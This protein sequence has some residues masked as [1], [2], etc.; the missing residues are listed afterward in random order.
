MNKFASKENWQKYFKWLR[1]MKIV[2]MIVVLHG[3][4]LYQFATVNQGVIENGRL[5]LKNWD[6]N[7]GKALKLDGMWRFYP[8]AFIASTTATDDMEATDIYVPGRWNEQL[9]SDLGYGSYQLQIQLNRNDTK[10]YAIYLP[11]IQSASR[12]YVNGE[13]AG[14]SGTPA[15]VKHDYEPYNIPY[16]VEAKGDENGVIDI[17]VEAANYVIEGQS[18]I[19]QA[20]QFGEKAVIVKRNEWSIIIQRLVYVVLLFHV[21]YT[22][23]L[24]IMGI[25]DK[26]LL[27]LSVLLFFILLII[28]GNGSKLIFEWAPLTYIQDYRIKGVLLSIGGFVLLRCCIDKDST[29]ILIYA[30][31]ILSV[32]AILLASYA[33]TLSDVIPL[34]GLLLFPIHTVTTIIVAV[35]GIILTRTIHR[36]TYMIYMFTAF[37]CIAGWEY[38]QVLLGISTIFYPFD[39]VVIIFC[40]SALVF[41]SY[42]STVE[43]NKQ[44][45]AKLQRED[46]LKDQF[47]ANTSHELRNPLH[48]MLNLTQ[49]VLDKEKIAL[50]QRSVQNLELVLSIGRRMNILL[51]DLLDISTLKEQ[52]I[53]LVKRNVNVHQLVEKTIDSL[54]YLLDRNRISVVNEVS[55]QLQPV[56]ADENRLMQI[57]FN[58]LHNAIKFTNQGGITIKA[59]PVNGMLQISVTDT[60]QGIA[61]ELLEHIFDSYQQISPQGEV[62][63][64]GFGL[65]LS[66]TKQLVELHGS[67]LKVRSIEGKGSTFYFSLP[68]AH[69]E[70]QSEAEN[71]SHSIANDNNR[72]FASTTDDIDREALADDN[73]SIGQLASIGASKEQEPQRIKILAVDDD[74]VNL[75]VLC[76][77]L[78]SDNELD[79]YCATSAME[80][81]EMLADQQWDIIISDVMM[82]GMSGHA[83]TSII[84]E[85]YGLNELPILLLT[86]RGDVLDVEAG[87]LAG[88]NDYVAK[89]I[90]AIELYAR[91][92]T[93]VRLKRSHQEALSL[94][95]AWLQAQ[96]KPHFIVNTLNSIVALSE[97]DQNQMIELVHQFSQYLRSSHSI[98]HTHELIGLEQELQLVE[99]FLS[100]NQHRFNKLNIEWNVEEG[101]DLSELMLP[102][103]VLQSLIENAVVHGALSRV[104]NSNVTIGIQRKDR[105]VQITIRDNGVGMSKEI[106]E[107]AL[108]GKLGSGIGLYN[109]NL[110]LKQ[111]Y[112]EGLTIHSQLGQGTEVSFKIP[113]IKVVE[114]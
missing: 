48:G 72:L 65:G 102:P 19:G 1:V 58:L 90:N 108:R 29:R 18:G 14:S 78:N 39:L 87:L 2:I 11:S 30:S 45:T 63:N 21:I 64:T 77:I 5:D 12:V 38:L 20:P 74:P 26:R 109:T 57:L 105:Y 44:L 80:A 56:L 41:K 71:K 67:Q 68:F 35:I 36:G 96:I 95:A 8:N 70:Q 81:L 7:S 55:P 3:V 15:A 97:I 112:R 84:R 76:N 88:A 91:V 46:K 85:T 66:I 113:I 89:P 33:L 101:N 86:A 93:L 17:I 51:G 83:L 28:A 53:Q 92:R 43:Q 47:L 60:G 22:L 42:L 6:S 25:R 49:A 99:A 103:L 37:F 34:I 59:E 10:T 69:G 23:Q 110:R 114:S 13:L 27:Y 32:A 40:I 107:Q 104:E 100:I 75:H 61:E 79:L 62:I 82:P 106:I 54:Q 24:Y 73:Q 94:E 111:H 16:I 98:H 31:R 50:D 4:W 9:G 52:G